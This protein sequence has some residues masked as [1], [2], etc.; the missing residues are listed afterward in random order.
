M[1]TYKKRGGKPKTKVDIQQS[2]EDGSTTAEV[3][4][5]LDEG[6]SKTEQWVIAKQKY[7][8]IIVGLAAVLILGFLGYDKY[9]QEPNER[10]AMNDMYTAQTYLM[11]PS[12]QQIKI[13]CLHFL[14]MAMALNT[15]CWILPK[16]MLALKP[17]I[18]PITMQ[19]WPT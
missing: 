4:N 7:I 18:W 9:I 1:A 5:T 2:I 11:K 3:F 13:H 12:L 10:T 19:G 6:V 8:F 14:S 17:G 15:A 16:P